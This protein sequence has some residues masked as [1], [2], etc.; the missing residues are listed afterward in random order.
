VHSNGFSLVRKIVEMSGLGF[1]APAPFSPVMTL[2]GALL[3][4]TRLYV[5]SCLRAI[6]ETGAVKGLAHITGG[7]FTDNIP[8]VLPKHLGVGIDLARLP[9]LPVFKWLAE[10]GGIAELELLRTFNCGIGMIAIVNP[11]QSSR[12]PKSSPRRRERRAARR[13]DP[14]RGRASRGL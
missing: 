10:Q 13:S 11:T 1:D 8:R 14:G 2:G 9:V 4:P 7:G 5:K 12:S 3:T 6:R